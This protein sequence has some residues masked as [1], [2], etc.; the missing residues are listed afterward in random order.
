MLAEFFRPSGLDCCSSL[1][2][3]LR[4]GLLPLRRFAAV[5]TPLGSYISAQQRAKASHEKAIIG[6]EAYLS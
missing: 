5:S 1:T 2:H 3:D 4:R 6:T